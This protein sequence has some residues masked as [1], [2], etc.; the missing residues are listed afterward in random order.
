MR[1]FQ[2]R[3]AFLTY[4]HCETITAFTKE[5]LNNCL[6]NL[7]GIESVT[8]G[9]ENYPTEE[10]FH[11]H[12]LLVFREKQKFL[13]EKFNYFGVVPFNENFRSQARAEVERVY[14]Y[15]IKDANFISNYSPRLAPENHWQSIAD[16]ESKEAALA[17]LQQFYPRDAIL[18]RRNF[19]YWAERA[20]PVVEQ[21]YVGGTF[22][23]NV[24]PVVQTWVESELPGTVFFLFVTNP[25]Y[26]PKFSNY[27][28]RFS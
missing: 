3:K 24:P 19:D 7:P 18:Q 16:A 17:L 10:G 22:D 20:Y 2:A 27:P 4:Q 15:C 9:Q 6:L 26:P 5:H 13:F 21:P 12:V 1:Y 23:F 14:K 28:L 8:V 11:C 25:P